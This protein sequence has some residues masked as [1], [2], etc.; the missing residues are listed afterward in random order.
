MNLFFQYSLFLIISFYS[1][2]FLIFLIQ[3]EFLYTKRMNKWKWL[4]IRKSICC[5]NSNNTKKNMNEILNEYVFSSNTNEWFQY[6]KVYCIFL[7]IE[8]WWLIVRRVHLQ[9]IYMPLQCYIYKQKI[10]VIPLISIQNKNFNL[11]IW[12]SYWF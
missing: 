11:I 3:M 8:S 4:S 12:F 5:F 7:E 6:L 2:F 10:N 1:Y 9:S